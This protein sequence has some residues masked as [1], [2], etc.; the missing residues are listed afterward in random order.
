M[1]LEVAF[2]I[3]SLLKNFQDHFYTNPEKLRVKKCLPFYDFCIK[4]LLLCCMV[5]TS[6]EVMRFW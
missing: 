2:R 5:A 3:L 1:R 6:V 4:L